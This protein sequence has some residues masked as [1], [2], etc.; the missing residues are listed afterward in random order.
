MKRQGRYSL[1]DPWWEVKAATER[2]RVEHG[3]WAY[4]HADGRLLGILV[5]ATGAHRIL[6][7]GTALGYT[8]L[9]LASGA[10]LAHVDTLE[11][12]AQHVALARAAIEKAGYSGLIEVHQGDFAALLPTLRVGYDLAFFD[13]YAPALAELHQLRRLL[14]PGGLLICAN[15]QLAGTETNDCRAQLLDGDRWLTAP[16]GDGSDVSLSIRRPDP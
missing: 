3:C 13:G 6:E 14:R 10:P 4:P 2:H 12:D 11:D 15:Q 7:L 1:D 8:A 9:W 5:A 16:L